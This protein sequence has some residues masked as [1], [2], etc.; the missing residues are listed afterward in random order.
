MVVDR[1]PV[2]HFFTRPKNFG[3]SSSKCWSATYRRP[4]EREGPYAI[5]GR[6]HPCSNAVRGAVRAFNPFHDAN[7]YIRDGRLGADG[8]ETASH[9]LGLADVGCW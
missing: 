1:L 3:V 2:I 9:V 7:S 8:D 6:R 4:D 5:T